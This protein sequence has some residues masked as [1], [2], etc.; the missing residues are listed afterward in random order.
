MHPRFLLGKV[1]I[2]YINE[3]IEYIVFNRADGKNPSLRPFAVA[4]TER[5]TNRQTDR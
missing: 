3:H 4:T 1:N 2:E 5:R